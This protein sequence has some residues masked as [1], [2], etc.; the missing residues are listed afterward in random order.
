MGWRSLGSPFLRI[1]ML[2]FFPNGHIGPDLPLPAREREKKYG[3]TTGQAH[4]LNAQ[5]QNLLTRLS[6]LPISILRNSS[7]N[8]RDFYNL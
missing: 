5:H 2:R 6:R 8:R 3:I 7:Q 4:K 1:L